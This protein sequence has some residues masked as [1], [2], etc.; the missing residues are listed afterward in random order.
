MNVKPWYQSKL[1][2]LSVMG[3]ALGV[4]E[5]LEGLPP[6]ASILT[7]IGGIIGVILRLVTNTAIAGTPAA[8]APKG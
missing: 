4:V 5:F 6:G 7:I 2:W 1:L 8:K 3:I